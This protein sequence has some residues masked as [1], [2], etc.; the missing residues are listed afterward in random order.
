MMG[1]I[2]FSLLFWDLNKI[3]YHLPDRQYEAAIIKIVP[4]YT[5]N[6]RELMRQNRAQKQSQNKRD[7]VSDKGDL[8]CN[9]EKDGFSNKWLELASWG[10]GKIVINCY[11][12]LST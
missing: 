8:Q 2:F 10:S 3:I 6:K 11:L 9:V 7:E 1:E 12:I 5:E 4:A